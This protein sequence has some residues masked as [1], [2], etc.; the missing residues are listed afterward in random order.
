MDISALAAVPEQYR[1]MSMPQTTPITIATGTNV[2]M[3]Y[4][5]KAN[6]IQKTTIL[7]SRRARRTIVVGL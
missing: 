5:G 3:N 6:T 2:K 7:S 1:A 4:D